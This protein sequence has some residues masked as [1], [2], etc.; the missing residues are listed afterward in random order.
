M[1]RFVAMAA[2]GASLLG[3][4]WTRPWNTDETERIART[5]E[6]ESFQPSTPGAEG[7]AVRDSPPPATGRF[8]YKLR[9][10]DGRRRV[11]SRALRRRALDGTEEPV[12]KSWRPL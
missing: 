12:L 6:P 9:P 1:N 10:F 11:Y 7:I 5:M 8:E 4:C 2:L 3:G